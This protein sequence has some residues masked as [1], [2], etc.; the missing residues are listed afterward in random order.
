MNVPVDISSTVIRTERLE[1]RPWR[2]SDLEDFFEYAS[3]D[4]VGQMA[5]WLPHEDIETSKRILASFIKGR[6][7]F[8]L[9][10]DGKVVG[11]LGVEEYD[12]AKFP[13][14]AD[15][16]CRELGFVLAKSCWGKGLMP[17][18][19]RGVLDWCFN[20][21]GLDA[22]FCGY[23]LRNAQSRR[24]QEKCGFRPIGMVKH[25]TRYGTVEDTMVNLITREEYFAGKE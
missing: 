1:L 21:L 3:V 2:E 10:L 20:E 17:E 22:V 19:V 11:S 13:E 8:A 24:A 12:E 9:E 18:A 25:E 15:K 5:G 23:F 14:F 7:V 16:R 4:G 6:R